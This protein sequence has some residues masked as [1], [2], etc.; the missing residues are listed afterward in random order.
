MSAT[1][2]DAE[3][4]LGGDRLSLA[5]FASRLIVPLRNNLVA[6]P[7]GGPK[8]WDFKGLRPPPDRPETIGEAFEIAAFDSDAEAKAYPSLIRLQDGS[9]VSLP[10]LLAKHGDAILGSAFVSRFGRCFPLLP[11]VLD[12]KELLSVQGHPAGNVEVYIIIDADPGATIGLGFNVDLDPEPFKARLKAGLKRQGDLLELLGEAADQHGLQQ[13]LSPWLA[14]RDSHS[15]ELEGS[16]P[17]KPG[18]WSAAARILDDLKQ[19]YW[20]VLGRLNAIPVAAGQVVYNAT[21]KRVVAERG[22]SIGAEVHAL[23]NPARREILALEIRRPGPTF[24]AWDNVRFPLR[25]VDVD[26]AIEALSLASTAPDEFLVEPAPIEGRAGVFVSVDCEF[27]RIEHLRPSAARPVEIPT[28]PPHCLHVLAGEVRVA[29]ADG[30]ELGQLV[31]G[32]SAIVPV[33]VGAYVATTL[34]ART[35]IIKV[36][37]PMGASG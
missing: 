4:L 5:E 20:D 33:G 23:G 32:D 25:A 35:E 36:S 18:D 13:R 1:P 15:S 26:A 29:H 34:S 14:A 28:E 12:V 3:A 31:R 27:F 37:L 17:I 6:R 2:T 9:T 7:W 22:C 21:P 30:S 8:I 16:L 10:S 24:R 19:A 11:K